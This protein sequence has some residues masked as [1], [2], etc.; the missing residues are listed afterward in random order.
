MSI[1]ILYEAIL[2]EFHPKKD[3]SCGCIT[4]KNGVTEWFARRGSVFG[5][6]NLP[7][8]TSMKRRETW[9]EACRRIHVDRGTVRTRTQ[10]FIEECRK[11]IVI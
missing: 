7:K 2:S 6:L 3:P 5:L 11:L 10:D 8:D 9:E 1:K 4:K